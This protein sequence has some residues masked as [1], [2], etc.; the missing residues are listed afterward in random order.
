MSDEKVPKCGI[1]MKV[2]STPHKPEE[3][4]VECSHCEGIHVVP[5]D[6]ELPALVGW[7]D[8]GTEIWVAHSTLWIP[9]EDK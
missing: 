3:T 9:A 8:D 1:P 4:M 7:R 6:H 2:P 5:P